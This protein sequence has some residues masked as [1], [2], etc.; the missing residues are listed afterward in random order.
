MRSAI[1]F[2][3]QKTELCEEIIILKNV[4]IDYKLR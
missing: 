4:V 3:T 1:Q 2:V